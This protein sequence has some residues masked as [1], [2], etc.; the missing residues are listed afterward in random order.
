MTHFPLPELGVGIVYHDELRPL[1]ERRPDLISVV[2]IEPQ[3]YWRYS[4]DGRQPYS[5]VR[6]DFDDLCALPQRKIVHGVGFP[7]G[8]SRSSDPCHL[9]LFCQNIEDLGATW[10]SEHLGFNEANAAPGRFNTGFVLPLLSTKAGAAAAASSVREVAAQLPVPFAIETGVNY[11]QPVAGELPDGAFFTAVVEAADCGIL[12]DVHNLWANECNGREPME[13]FL[14]ELPLDRVWEI[15]VAGGL[16]LDGYWLDAHSGAIPKPVI[17]FTQRILPILPNLSA[18][19]F[20]ILPTFLPRLGLEGVAEQLELLDALWRSRG[21]QRKNELGRSNPTAYNA[22]TT[23]NKANAQASVKPAEWE[24]ALGALVVGW[25][26]MPSLA[27]RLA[28]DPG[29]G[30]FQR[31]VSDLRAGRIVSVLRLTSSVM[32]LYKGDHWL[33]GLL[34]E[35]FARNPPQLFASSEAEAFAAF[36]FAQQ[37]DMPHLSEILAFEQAIIA[38]QKSS[39]SI[40]VEWPCDPIPVFEALVSGRLPGP[41]ESEPHQ[42]IIASGGR[43]ESVTRTEQ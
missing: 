18:I 35:F 1:I 5:V 33:E 3:M 6:P 10:A 7:I 13:A 31:L 11:L 37:L 2:E 12:L 25:P 9:P 4:P 14:A 40:T 23:F 38:S 24:D 19:I 43:L 22:P 16:E 28:G 39:H 29:I 36:V 8:G 15:H 27:S 26:C 41:V 34:C 21:E 17:E 20:E 32:L 42:I 30:I